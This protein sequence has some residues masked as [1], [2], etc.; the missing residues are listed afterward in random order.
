MN[1]D[2]TE[3]IQEL[4]Q[5]LASM[6]AST[7]WRLTAPLRWAGMLARRLRQ[8]LPLSRGRI[9]ASSQT[10]KLETH[11]LSVQVSTKPL[12]ERISTLSK[13]RQRVAYFAEN[14]H[15]STFRY[16]A[17]NMAEVLN[18]PSADGSSAAL[19][20]SAACFFSVDL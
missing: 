10:V 6:R 11:P 12:Q 4:E 16:R 2:L 13:G 15:S 1:G 19:P 5:Q 14:V 8:I 7:S 17:A 18:A 3:K 9:D 20:T